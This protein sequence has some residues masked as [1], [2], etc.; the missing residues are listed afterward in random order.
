MLIS[1][2]LKKG[3]SEIKE[4]FIGKTVVFWDLFTAI[5]IADLSAGALSKE[6]YTL[7]VILIVVD[8]RKLFV[9]VAR[10][11]MQELI[12]LPTLLFYQSLQNLDLFIHEVLNAF[13]SVFVYFVKRN[14][15]V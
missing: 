14:R 6:S 13:F 7:Q 1:K 15:Y 2:S 3:F 9:C 5:Q 11:F 8:N 4:N 10:Q 12:T